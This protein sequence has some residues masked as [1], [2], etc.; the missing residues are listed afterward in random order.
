M[1]VSVVSDVHGSFDALARVADRAEFLIVLGDL[2]EYVDYYEPSA[3]ILGSV[4]GADA[5]MSFAKLRK[6]GEFEKMHTYESR[7]WDSLADPEATLAEIVR[8][9]Y[10]Q[11]VTLMPSNAVVTLGNVDDPRAWDS[12]A[13][14]HLRHRDGEC[15]D[16]DGVRVGFVAGGCLKRPPTTWPWSY[17]ERTPEQYLERVGR[18]EALDVLCSHVPPDLQDLRYDTN[19]ERQEM[20]GRGLLE[21]ID[22]ERPGMALSGHVHHPRRHEVRRGATRCINVGFF[23]GAREPFVFETEAVRAPR[24]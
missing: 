4:F 15:V 11:V 16:V 8:M 7:L 20:Y 10:E 12:I 14:A 18:L 24:D 13:P 21:L 6:A 19:A 3:G 17:Y 9:Q 2:L 23:K 22:R 1:L 5:V